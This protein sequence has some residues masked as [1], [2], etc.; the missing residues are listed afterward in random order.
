MNQVAR[1]AQLR[2]SG[3]RRKNWFAASVLLF[4]GLAAGCG[5]QV[6]DSDEVA[7]RTSAVVA[8]N[9]SVD[10]S[11]IVQIKITTCTATPLST[12]LRCAYC[13]VAPDYILIGGG[14]QILGSPA[15]GRLK[16]SFPDTEGPALDEGCTGDSSGSRSTEVWMARSYSS[17]TANPTAHQ[18]QAYSV[19]LKIAGMTSAELRGY[20]NINENSNE[21]VQQPTLA[22]EPLEGY[23]LIGGGAELLGPSAN[24]RSG[25]LT[26]LRPVNPPTSNAWSATGSF[27]SGTIGGLKVFAVG[28]KL[29]LPIPGG[30]SLIRKWRTATSSSGTGYRSVSATTP[31]SWAS[32]G[33]GASE[34]TG[35]G[36]IRYLADLIPLSGSSPGFTVTTK[37]EGTSVS[38]SVVGYACNIGSTAGLYAYNGVASP[39]VGVV[40]RPSGTNPQLQISLFAGADQPA[41]RWHFEPFGTGTY[42]LRNGNP[43]SGTECAYRDGS[44]SIVRVKACG[45]GNEFRWSLLGDPIGQQAQVR[46]V[47]NAQCL[48]WSTPGSGGITNLVLK[49]CGGSSAPQYFRVTRFNWP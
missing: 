13:P 14:A 7:L 40:S 10:A 19:G 24:G 8:T 43:E 26:D 34:V 11:G 3:E 12:G 30:S 46:N 37:D 36:A 25:F 4:G 44:T 45:T 21:F 5:D 27:N 15:S 41:T 33:V 28:I 35:G 2:R 1:S 20:V 49:S 42:R 23:A 32:A 39:G 9:D 22:V 29:D 31:S 48:D 47:A 6:D 17:T 16:A 38:G 18:L